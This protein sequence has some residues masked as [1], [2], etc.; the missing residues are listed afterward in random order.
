MGSRR[1][2]AFLA[3]LVAAGL[4]LTAAFARRTDETPARSH[5][6]GHTG[7]S[8]REPAGGSTKGPTL[9]GRRFDVRD[10]ASRGTKGSDGDEPLQLVDAPFF[11]ADEK[12]VPI[13]GADVRVAGTSFST[14]EKGRVLLHVPTGIGTYVLVDKDGY[15][16]WTGS[17][18]P[19]SPETRIRLVSDPRSPLSIRLTGAEIADGVEVHVWLESRTDEGVTE[20]CLAPAKGRTVAFEPRVSP[21][22]YV[23]AAS[24]PGLVSGPAEVRVLAGVA[25]EVVVEMASPRTIRGTVKDRRG[26]AVGDGS[27]SWRQRPAG[28]CGQGLLTPFG[29]DGE[30]VLTGVPNARVEVQ[31]SA[32]DHTTESATVE[33]RQVEVALVLLARGT[34]EGTIDAVDGGSVQGLSVVALPADGT[35]ASPNDEPLE[36][37]HESGEFGFWLH[38]GRWRLHAEHGLA[39][40]PEATVELPPAGTVKIALLPP[41]RGL[42]IRGQVVQESGEPGPANDSIVVFPE[43]GNPR[44]HAVR[45]T[46][47]EEGRFEAGRLPPGRY[48][49]ILYTNGPSAWRSGIESGATDVRLV[50]ADRHALWIELSGGPRP[51]ADDREL[52][53]YSAEALIPVLQL[54][55][56]EDGAGKSFGLPPGRYLASCASGPLVAETSEP[57]S[58]SASSDDAL[59]IRLVLAPGA[60]VSGVVRDAKKAPVGGAQVEAHRM[61]LA[62]D[63][64]TTSDENG[65]FK[66]VGLLPGTWR[67]VV[68]D[69]AGL[70]THEAT[71]TVEGGHAYAVDLKPVAK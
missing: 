20:E 7:P 69:A 4:V 66:F 22:S 43:D 46:T 10:T 8:G 52:V 40:G 38:E 36:R 1:T 6:A 41:P 35:K 9:A 47:D 49:L 32:T 45:V 12:G 61:R 5:A 57:A 68:R 26:A 19:A 14:D 63:K 27:A 51:L 29:A 42:S 18:D 71:V 44:G 31:A 62:W 3:T 23:V 16:R 17:I 2:A 65:A 70:A 39:A 64:T 53:V 34:I 48:A 30:F 60:T 21:G 25:A 67:L 56:D 58:V 54:A 59:S 37:V 11:V 50:R 24:A 13:L 55:V 15:E 28:S 33:E